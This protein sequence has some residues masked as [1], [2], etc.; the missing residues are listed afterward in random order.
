MASDDIAKTLGVVET[1]KVEL[2]AY[3]YW[4]LQS[5]ADN[6]VTVLS[7]RLK[8]VGFLLLQEAQHLEDCRC[9]AMG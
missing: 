3:K 5:F 6:G 1:G 4:H 9:L 2:V 8:F 7:P